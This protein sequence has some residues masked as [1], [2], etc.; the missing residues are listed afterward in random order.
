MFDR[1]LQK[2]DFRVL[3]F[4]NLNWDPLWIMLDRGLQKK[5]F[6]CLSFRVIDNKDPGLPPRQGPRP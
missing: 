4:E 6:P 3:V 5:R 2:D 1:D